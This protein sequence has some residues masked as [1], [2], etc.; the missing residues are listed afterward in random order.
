[1]V[2]YVSPAWLFLSGE[3]LISI[4]LLSFDVAISHVPPLFHTFFAPAHAGEAL[5]SK[6]G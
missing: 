3:R 4:G 1:M 5:G 2:T 6:D